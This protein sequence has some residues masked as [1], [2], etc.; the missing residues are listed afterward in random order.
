MKLILSAFEQLSG[1]K[2]NYH[3]SELFCFGEAQVVTTQYAEIFGCKQCQFPISYLVIPVHYRGL[4][5]SEWKHVEG[6]LKNVVVAG[7]ESY[8]LL[9]GDWFL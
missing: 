7:K 8:Y 5:N 4:T 3:K 2:I 9:V 6:A 1:L